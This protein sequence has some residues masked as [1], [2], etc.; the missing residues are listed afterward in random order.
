MTDSLRSAEDFI[1]A[2]YMRARPF[3]HGPDER[4][5]RPVLT[6]ELLDALGHPERGLTCLLVAGSKGKGSTAAFAAG[7]LATS[8]RPIGLFPSP[9]LLDIRERI[10]VDGRAIPPADCVEL[11]RRLRS[12]AEP[13]ATS[14]PAGAYLSPVGLLL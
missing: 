14:L 9:H 4:A 10:R 12:V 3:L 11:V 2:S 6:A 5:R 1:F 7:L 13:V 8:G